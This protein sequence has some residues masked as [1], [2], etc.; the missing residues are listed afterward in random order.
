LNDAHGQAWARMVTDV[1]ALLADSLYR[2]QV[3][4]AGANDMELDW[5]TPTATRAWV[6]GY[7]SVVGAS[8]YL[9]NFGDAA[10]CPS[11]RTPSG[12]DCGTATH[13]EWTVE[14]VYHISWGA[15]S[16][17]PLPQIYRNDGTNARQWYRLSLYAA[18]RDGDPMILAGSLT[19][20]GACREKGC[21][22]SVDNTPSEGWAQ[23]FTA[24]NTNDVRTAQH[25][26]W[27]TDIR[28]SNTPR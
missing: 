6:D 11:D 9:Y 7:S 25:L 2:V 14:D 22:T 12:N 16:A 5:N 23:L 10:G 21:N 26:P 24:L 3:D 4:V 15:Q 27:S 8:Y 28:F 18:D 13:P 19:Q 17:I 1:A 20:L